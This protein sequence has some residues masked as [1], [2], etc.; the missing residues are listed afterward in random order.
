MDFFKISSLISKRL[1][2]VP[3][4]WDGKKS[5]IEMKENG[6]KQW[7]QME[8]IGFYFEYL[9][10]KSLSDIMEMPGIR[11]GNVSFDG[12]YKFPWDFKA[13]SKN[14][15]SKMIVNDTE[16]TSK[17]IE[18]Y[19]CVGLIVASGNAHYDDDNRS[20]Y[21]W[22]EKLKGG[23]SKY[24]L[25]RIQRKAPSRQRKKSFE[26]EEILFIK[27]TDETLIKHGSFQKNFR[28]SNGSPRRVK[29]LIDLEGLDEELIHIIH[30]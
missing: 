20:F 5:I 22:H 7:K 13:H 10:E 28:N 27:I 21:R 25:E 26:L 2:N 9:C 8:W 11:Y 23:K 19:G 1:E 14:S 6:S 29:V 12:F 15:S 4:S 17:A 16:A 3:K 30:F 24:E 18:D